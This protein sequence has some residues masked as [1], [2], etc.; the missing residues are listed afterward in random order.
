[1]YEVRPKSFQVA[2]ALLNLPEDVGGE[3]RRV[4]QF[5]LSKESIDRLD[6]RIFPEPI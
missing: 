5:G 1:M 6:P 4:I 3:Q 2:A